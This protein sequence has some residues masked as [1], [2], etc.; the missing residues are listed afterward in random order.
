MTVSCRQAPSTANV[1]YCKEI[2]AMPREFTMPTTNAI[3]YGKD[4]LGALP[5]VMARREPAE[6]W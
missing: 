2:A 4:A 5:D 1:L 3:V 6:R